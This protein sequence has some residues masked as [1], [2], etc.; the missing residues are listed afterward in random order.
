MAPSLKSVEKV[1]HEAI[2][3]KCFPYEISAKDFFI[4]SENLRKQFAVFI[5]APDF[6]NTAIIPSVSYAMANVANNIELKAGQEII[7][8]DEQ[9][10]SNVYAWQKVADKNG[11]T[12]KMVTPPSSFENRG[13]VDGSLPPPVVGALF[14]WN[15][16]LL[17][18]FQ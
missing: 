13:D 12:L 7:I 17:R 14:F 1:G 16:L 8:A 3:Q 6:L 4:H 11:A 10:P 18:L 9:F 5:E 15:G 2:T